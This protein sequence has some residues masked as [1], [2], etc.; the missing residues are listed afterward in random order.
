MKTAQWTLYSVVKDESFST[1]LRNEARMSAFTSIQHITRKINKRHS[2]WKERVKI[3]C[4]QVIWSYMVV[5]QSLSC[6]WLF[7][8]PRTAAHHVSLSFTISRSLLKLISIESMM[9]SNHLILCNPLILLLSIFPSIRFFSNES[10]RHIR[11]PKY[12]NFSISISPSNE[13]SGLFSF[14]ID[15][16]DLLAVQGDLKSLLQHHSSEASILLCSAFFMVQLS[17]LYITPGKTI[18]LTRWTFVQK[19]NIFLKIHCLGLS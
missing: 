9:P 18:D 5:V 19:S 2:N 7:A 4:L 6:L 3:T 11:W 15:W 12:W 13:Y 14:R 16:F 17:H 8:T 1:M 10:A